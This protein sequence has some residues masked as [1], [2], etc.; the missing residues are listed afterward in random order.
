MYNWLISTLAAGASAVVY[1]ESPLEPDVDVLMKIVADTHSTMFG[2]GAKIF[3]EYAKRGL[4]FCESCGVCSRQT[5]KRCIQ[6]IAT[7]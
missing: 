1:D 7:I 2:A 3:D 4:N 5:S 6:A